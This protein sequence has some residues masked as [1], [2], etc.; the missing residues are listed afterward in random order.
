MSLKV[1]SAVIFDWDNTLVDTW[2][3]IHESMNTTLKELGYELW[4]IEETKG[5]V[6]RSLREAFP[7]LFGN[8]W[9]LARDIF[10][11]RFKKIHLERLVALEGAEGLLKLLYSKKIYLCVVS[12]KSGN[13]LRRE[14][15]HLD[16]NRYF[17]QIVGAMDTK[18]DKPS[19]EPVLLALEGSQIRPSLDVWF[20]GDTKIDME[21]AYNSGCL[22]ILISKIPPTS[23]EFGKF[24]PEMNFSSCD[25]L[26]TLASTL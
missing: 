17:G 11:R 15:A 19:I 2:P 23:E 12:N 25:M 8:K 5:R 9:E 14:A 3:V 20:I 24:M 10:Y 13:N 7:D 1:P 16:W 21:C 4:S 22:P 6:R 26:T 18:R